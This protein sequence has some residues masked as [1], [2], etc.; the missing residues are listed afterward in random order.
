MTNETTQTHNTLDTSLEAELVETLSAIS[1]IAKGLS[2]KVTET[3]RSKGEKC[4]KKKCEKTLKA[5]HKYGQTDAYPWHGI[6]VPIQI[7]EEHPRFF[8]ARV[9]RHHAPGCFGIS[10]PY[11]VTL[12]KHD[13][14]V[15]IIIIEG[16]TI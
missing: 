12:D 15:G 4:M 13:I 9:L 1:V 5:R 7:I 3:H 8:V 14:E 6:A 16:G 2:K 10:V 11:N